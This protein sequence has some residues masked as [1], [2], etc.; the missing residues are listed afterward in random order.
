MLNLISNDVY[1]VD[2][3][4]YNLRFDKIRNVKLIDNKEYMERKKVG[5]LGKKVIFE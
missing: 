2:I 1:E 3:N 5:F 4:K